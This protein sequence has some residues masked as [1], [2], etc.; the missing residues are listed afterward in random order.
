M[1]HFTV[2]VCVQDKDGEMTVE[3]AIAAANA[4]L[5]PFQENNMGDCPSEYMEFNEVDT[6]EYL[7]TY[8]MDKKLQKTYE[9]FE[10]Y[11]YEEIGY[12]PNEDGKYGYWE[13]PNAKWDWYSIGGRWT[14]FFP[15]KDN[16]NI[17]VGEPGVFGNKAKE[18]MADIV[19]VKDLDTDKLAENSKQAMEEFWDNWVSLVTGSKKSTD[20]FHTRWSACNMGL[21]N[22][23]FGKDMTKEELTI[24]NSK[25]WDD[26]TIDK[27]DV[28]KNTTRDEFY[29]KYENYFDKMQTY[30][31]LDN[32]GWHA[33]GDMGWWGMSS[34]STDE[35]LKFR[36]SFYENFVSKLEQNDWLIIVDCHI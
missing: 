24:S 36:N 8:N 2:L 34:E 14:G 13:N 15:V 27:Y 4:L 35:K 25:K 11:M 23:K 5:E 30:A 6:E 28:Y 29:L 10:E 16:K 31:V 22:V 7:K 17:H 26:D 3:E 12:K 21:I 33:P 32:E 19:R 18:G 1:S 9:N 20:L